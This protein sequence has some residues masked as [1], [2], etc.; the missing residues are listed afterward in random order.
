[1][2]KLA[3]LIFISFIYHSSAIY[4][5]NLA[6]GNPSL[7]DAEQTCLS[8]KELAFSISYQNSYSNKYFNED[9]V[10]N[11]IKTLKNAYS[12]YAEFKTAYGFTPKFSAAV[13]LGYFFNKTINYQ[14]SS[15]NGYG[16]GDAAIY[17]KY[18]LI[19][20]KAAKFT[21]LP[22]IGIKLP[23]GVFDQ[24]D[25]NTKLP[26]M[27]Q[28]SSGNLKYVVS[29]YMQKVLNEKLS[30]ASMCSYEYAQ[31]IDSKNFY[32]KYGDQ[33][34]L[35]F[36]AKYNFSENFSA[37]LQ[38]RFENRDK[39]NKG[40]EK[41]IESSGY[42]IVFATPQI[43]YI[44]GNNWQISAYADVPVYRY[45]NGIQL[46]QNYSLYVRLSKKIDFKF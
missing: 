24:T 9:R 7:S 2:R 43:T 36:F 28:P 21:L 23:I 30:I 35:S 12:N 31:L 29:V 40:F 45:Y 16:L 44:F 41:I 17:L 25:G 46:A 22:A 38:F 27:L 14:D 37:N 10:Y 4:G 33:W 39:E 1:M 8:D 19:Y 18:R 5:Q 42:K 3:I 15:R 13:E 11:G 20:S 6:A 26:I 32:Y 34:K